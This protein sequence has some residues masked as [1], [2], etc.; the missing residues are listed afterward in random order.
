MPK[1]TD[2]TLNPHRNSPQLQLYSFCMY[3]KWVNGEREG[4]TLHK[5]YNCKLQLVEEEG[6][7]GGGGGRN[8]D[9]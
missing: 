4:K 7:R 1:G 5:L 2:Q 3:K 8:T 9:F 6:G